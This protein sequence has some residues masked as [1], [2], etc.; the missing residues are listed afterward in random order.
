MLLG[1]NVLGGVLKVGTPLCCP[2]KN[3]L[4]VGVVTGIQRNKKDVTEA[5]PADGGVSVKINNAKHVHAG[6]QFTEANQLA[7][8]LNRKS[9]DAL[10]TY[11]KDEMTKADWKLVIRLKEV[12]GVE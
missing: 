1:M 7:S 9:I 10:K 8:M 2:D 12:L 6:K 5:R 4:K 3:N 11:Y